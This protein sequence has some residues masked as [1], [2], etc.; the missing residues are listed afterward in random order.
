[1]AGVD[2]IQSF[3]I[4]HG[5]SNPEPAS[6]PRATAAMCCCGKDECVYLRHNN[7]ALDGLERDVRQAARLGQV[8]AACISPSFTSVLNDGAAFGV[9]NEFTNVFSAGITC[10]P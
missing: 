6:I 8:C 9:R 10:A 7:Q 1:M 4:S 5:Q 3:L 2:A